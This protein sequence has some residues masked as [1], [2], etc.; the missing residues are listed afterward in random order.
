M[1]AVYVFRDSNTP[2]ER[3]EIRTAAIEEIRPKQ[4]LLF[5]FFRMKSYSIRNVLIEFLFIFLFND[6]FSDTFEFFEFFRFF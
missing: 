1:A 3:G 4:K 2:N 5:F 6:F